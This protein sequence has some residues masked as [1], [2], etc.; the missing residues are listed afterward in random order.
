MRSF[1]LVL[2][3]CLSVG[4]IACNGAPLDEQSSLAN[5]KSF[6]S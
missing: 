5:I 2:A 6:P 4:L 3:P 1:A